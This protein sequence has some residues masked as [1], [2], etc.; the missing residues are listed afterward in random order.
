ML[1]ISP[2][3]IIHLAKLQRAVLR[4]NGVRYSIAE[5]KGLIELLRYVQVNPDP[6]YYDLYKSFVNEL[7]S[8][9]K[10]ALNLTQSNRNE[11]NILIQP[12]QPTLPSSTAGTAR[13]YRGVKIQSDDE[14]GTN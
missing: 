6:R 8:D 14:P 3:S 4:V 10:I 7:T 1:S 5:E 13:Y 11:P 9:E 2:K 12:S